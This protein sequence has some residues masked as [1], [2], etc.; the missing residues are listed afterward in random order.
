MRF[1]QVFDK[2]LNIGLR[3]EL[4]HIIHFVVYQLV[5]LP[6]IGSWLM[7]RISITARAKRVITEG[8]P[9]RGFIVSFNGSSMLIH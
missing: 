3:P 9:K 6:S 2:L 7:G 8:M 5:H 4:G 1:S